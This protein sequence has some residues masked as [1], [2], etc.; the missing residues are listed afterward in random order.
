MLKP[1]NLEGSAM[2]ANKSSEQKAILEQPL[3]PE[4][5]KAELSKAPVRDNKDNLWCTYCKK[6]RHTRERCWKLHGKPPSKDW[7]DK[8]GQ[9]RS[10]GQA[11][12]TTLQNY[13]H[14]TQG[15][16][17]KSEIEKLRALLGTL[18]KPSGT[19]SLA[20]SGPGFGEDDW[21]C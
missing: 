15:E 4:N 14:T 3:I 1:Q 2:V 6:S 8:G 21:T 19:C 17:N 13:E 20:H 18:E 16:F 9:H 12:V 5:G 10:S 7:G 11:H